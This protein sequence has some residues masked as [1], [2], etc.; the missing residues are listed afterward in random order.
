MEG[1]GVYWSIVEDLYQ[2]AN[3]LP[4]DTEGIAFDY[5]VSENIVDFIINDS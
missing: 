2:N 5:R 3:A 4:M 1:Y